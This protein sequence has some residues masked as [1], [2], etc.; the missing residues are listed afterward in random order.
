M[1][2]IVVDL[3]HSPV[4]SL[5]WKKKQRSEVHCFVLYY[6]LPCRNVQIC[7]LL[8]NFA[9]LFCFVTYYTVLYFAELSPTIQYGAV[10]YCTCVL[11]ITLSRKLQPSSY[12]QKV[13]N[14]ATAPAQFSQD[15][16]IRVLCIKVH[17][18]VKIS[19]QE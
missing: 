8:L 14:L 4:L 17:Q 13:A 15:T 16:G 2:C 6:T 11:S 19:L 7:L 1:F 3:T 18:T 9:I 12:Q 10:L 5:K